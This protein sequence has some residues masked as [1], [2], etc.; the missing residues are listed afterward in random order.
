[1]VPECSARHAQSFTTVAVRARR[2]RRARSKDASWIS[3]TLAQ[4]ARVNRSK[5]PG[6]GGFMA[7]ISR[8]PSP[9]GG[10]NVA[11]G[12]KCT[13]LTPPSALYGANGMRFGPDGRLYVAQAFGSQI[14]AIDART[15]EVSVISPVGGAIVGPDDLA[16]DSK[17]TLYATEVMSERVCAR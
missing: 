17:G 16:F 3:A 14:S 2:K 4:P 5:H 12:W 1:M 13:H 10:L 15:G 8:Y 6:G 7:Q 11:A 9:A